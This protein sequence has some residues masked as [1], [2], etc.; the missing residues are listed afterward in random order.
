MAKI[1]NFSSKQPFL[2]IFVYFCNMK[3]TL[4]TYDEARIAIRDGKDP[5]AFLQL[6]IIYAKGLGITENHRLA[7]YFFEKALAMGCQEADR[8]IDLEYDMEKRNVVADVL[9]YFNYRGS[10]TPERMERIMRQLEKERKRKYYGHLSVIRDHLSSYYPDYNREKGITDILEGRNTV[11]ADL[12]YALST[13]DNHY[14]IQLDVAD[15]F[16]TQLFAPVTEDQELLQQLIEEDNLNILSEDENELMMGF[17]NFTNTY[18]KICSQ[19]DVD[20]KELLSVDD[21]EL[22]PYIK[23]S[24]LALLRRQIFRCLLSVKDLDPLVAED[25]RNT[26]HKDTELLEIAEKIQTEGLTDLLLY[27]V[28]TNI[29]IDALEHTYYKLKRAFLEGNLEPL[30][31]FLNAY[32]GRLN[33][34]DI[35]HHL[36]IFT[37]QNLPKIQLDD[38]FDE[39]T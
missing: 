10:D 3:K 4:P 28:E 24:T 12:L 20:Q 29:N 1:I 33:E 17:N 21:I 25:F 11:D 38:C 16:L 37:P 2:A 15:R 30:A 9:L 35:D 19:Y 34:E 5:M 36:P 13:S 6:G 22:H 23:I 18:E 26:L 31:T 7:N 27:F 14:E 32:V 39:N 8:Y